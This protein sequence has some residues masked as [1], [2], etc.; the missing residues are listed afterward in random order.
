MNHNPVGDALRANA[1]GLL[2]SEAAVNLL[3][4]HQYWLT[5][6]DF[7]DDFVDTFDG[8]TDGTPMAAL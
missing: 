7:L 6:S 4:G 2:A 3:I 8:L 1:A 5:R